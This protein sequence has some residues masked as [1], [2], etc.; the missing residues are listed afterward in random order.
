MINLSIPV[1]KQF[2]LISMGTNF[3][4]LKVPRAGEG[5][6]E[7]TKL[8]MHSNVPEMVGHQ[9]LSFGVI[10]FIMKISDLMNF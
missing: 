10:S 6:L 2:C 5:Y 8:R 4:P 9:V 1:S 7:D 3:G